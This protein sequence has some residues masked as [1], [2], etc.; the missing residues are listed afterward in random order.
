MKFSVLSLLLLC[1]VGIVAPRDAGAAASQWVESQGGRVRLVTLP[2][3]A[4]GNIRGLLDIR[5]LPGWKTYW[6][7]PGESGIPPEIA[8][9]DAAGVTLEKI[10]F[11]LPK[12]FDDGTTRYVGYDRS[13]GLPL[14]LRS[15]GGS[16]AVTASVFLGICKEICIPLQANLTAD[17][18]GESFAN[19]LDVA[20]VEQ[21]EARL[22]AAAG[23]AFRVT[24][25]SWDAQ[26]Q[27]LSVTFIAPAGGHLPEAFASGDGGLQFGAAVVTI[28]AD[29]GYT[30]RIPLVHKP[31]ALDLPAATILFTAESGDT[32]IETPLALD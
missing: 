3:D 20:A 19:P 30:A 7:D 21:A 5:L 9:P 11:P 32:A 31:K 6:R 28:A 22:P 1:L 15:S 13:V 16:Q 26:Q 2:A 14:A 12:R 8:L 4:E 24:A 17:A 23:G 10:G 18:G 27:H 29:G 25:A